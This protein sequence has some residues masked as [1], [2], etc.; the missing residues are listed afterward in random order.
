MAKKAPAKKQ[1]VATKKVAT[2]VKAAPLKQQ[3]VKVCAEIC[4]LQ[5]L[6]RSVAAQLDETGCLTAPLHLL[7]YE[8]PLARLT[9]LTFCGGCLS[10]GRKKVCCLT[11]ELDILVQE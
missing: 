7:G 1:P 6:R 9:A 4:F 3:P 2:A 11:C 8:R 5:R 10:L